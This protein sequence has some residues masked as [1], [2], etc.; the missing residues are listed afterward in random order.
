MAKQ[1]K[2]TGTEDILDVYVTDLKH[3]A[4]YTPIDFGEG[5]ISIELLAEPTAVH[6]LLAVPGYGWGRS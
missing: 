4:R 6:V 2:F 5:E 1:V 3:R